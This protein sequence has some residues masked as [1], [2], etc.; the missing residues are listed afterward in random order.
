MR[1]YNIVIVENDEDEQ[2]FMK[3]GF[4]SVNLFQ[5]KDQLK[6]GDEL[7]EWLEEHEN[8]LPDLIL[9]DLN[10]PGKNG[11]DIIET[12]KANPV[13]SHIPVIVTS[14]S[15]TKTIIDKC[16]DMGAADYLVKPETFIKYVPYIENLYNRINEKQL[17]K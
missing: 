10:M 11:Y 13:Y 12:V 15:S 5:I 9:T 17:V 8:D 6:N 3:E 2:F 14:T 4:D 16:L 1:K 7:F